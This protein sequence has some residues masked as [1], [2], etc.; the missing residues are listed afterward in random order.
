MLVGNLGDFVVTLCFNFQS[1]VYSS[2]FLINLWILLLLSIALPTI[3]Y[4]K[5]V[6]QTKNKARWTIT[7]SAINIIQA[8][9]KLFSLPKSVLSFLRY[10]TLVLLEYKTQCPLFPTPFLYS[11]YFSLYSQLLPFEIPVSYLSPNLHT[12]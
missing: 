9:W 11:K 1:S 5:L 12:T 3:E 2:W 10:P 7:E 6:L 4:F 8:L